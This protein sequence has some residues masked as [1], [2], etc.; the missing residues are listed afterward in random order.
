MGDQGLILN[1]T[2]GPVSSAGGAK[3]FPRSE[4]IKGSWV[5][6]L[7]LCEVLFSFV[8][9]ITC[10]LQL[11]VRS[12][13]Q[14]IFNCCFKPQ[15][16][17]IQRWILFGSSPSLAI[18][19]SPGIILFKPYRGICPHIEWVKCSFV[20]RGSRRSTRLSSNLRSLCCGND[21]WAQARSTPMC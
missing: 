17:Y 11:N 19:P 7:H 1:I 13:L 5:S 2:E 10:L 12:A 3:H 8:L 18:K 16:N 9:S 4:K 21:G 20:C 14:K 15:S 6:F